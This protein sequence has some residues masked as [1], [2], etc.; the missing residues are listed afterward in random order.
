MTA[1]GPRPG[2]AGTGGVPSPGDASR[3]AP[4]RT[5]A[6]QAGPGA[7][8]RGGPLLRAQVGRLP[9][10]RLPRRRRRRPGQPQRE[11]AHPV[12][13]RA[14]RVAAG[15]PARAVRGRRRDRDR[16]ARTA[17]TSTPSPSGSTRPTR[18]SSCCS[19]TT[20][21][22]FVAFDLLA[23]GD[24]D[25]QIRALRRPP[26]LARG[27]PRPGAS[28]RS[29]SPRSRPSPTWPATGSRA[30]RGPGW[31]AWWSRTAPSR[32]SRTSGP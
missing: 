26:G 8:R 21:A 9:V 4:G 15:Q 24:A 31:T 2:P 13:P 22:S 5:D 10:H 3:G 18:G 1:E 16:R 27:G 25:L 11:A 6:G 17:S 7:A 23:L 19:Q 12:L 20:P 14:G 28:P 29:T 32:T 30:S